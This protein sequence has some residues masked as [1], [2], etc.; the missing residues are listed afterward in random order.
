MALTFAPSVAAEGICQATGGPQ[1]LFVVRYY[2]D[3]SGDARFDHVSGAATAQDLDNCSGGG[4]GSAILPANIQTSRGIYQLGYTENFFNRCFAY[5]FQPS[6]GAPAP[7]Q[8]CGV[9]HPDTSNHDSYTYDIWLNNTSEFNMQVRFKIVNKSDSPDTVVWDQTFN[10]AYNN[11]GEFAW[12]GA[13]RQENQSSLGNQH[14]DSTHNI[15]M[16][17]MKYS[18]TALSFDLQVNGLSAA[19]IC[20]EPC[21]GNWA[22]KDFGKTTGIDSSQHY[23]VGTDNSPNDQVDFDNTAN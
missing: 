18:T 23:H 11:K 1:K 3:M 2:T 4:G 6:G 13:E 5:V 15:N 9:E 16:R 10:T 19:N 12:W 20:T 17:L 7:I 14:D 22:G 21:G 8:L